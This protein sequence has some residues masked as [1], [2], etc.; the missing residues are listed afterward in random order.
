MNGQFS[1]KL[2]PPNLN[3]M[4]NQVPH[5]AALDISQRI[6]NPSKITI[7]SSI[8]STP[9][10]SRNTPLS[11]NINIGAAPNDTPSAEDLKFKSKFLAAK[12]EVEQMEK[13]LGKLQELIDTANIS[14]TRLKFEKRLLLGAITAKDDYKHA[15]EDTTSE[16]SIKESDENNTASDLDTEDFGEDLEFEQPKQRQT[17]KKRIKLLDPKAPKRPANAFIMFCELSR[18]SIKE[19]RKRTTRKA[20]GSETDIQLLNLTKA[21][22]ARWR[23]L[24]EE[25][26]KVY[27]D[28]FKEQV[29]QY[30]QDFKEY[31]MLYPN[32][33]LEDAQVNSLPKNWTDPDAPTR[34]ANAFFVFC[35]MEDE[36]LKKNRKLDRSEK[37]EEEE[38]LLLSK[39]YGERWRKLS[40]FDRKGILLL[41]VYVEKYEEGVRKYREYMGNKKQSVDVSMG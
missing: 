2:P 27:Q 18:N 11:V 3:S 16:D 17:R 1:T 38:L 24:E 4:Q 22:G 33:P 34:S 32:A 21:L 13:E 5:Q 35:E 41:I 12:S 20:P 29:K 37:E 28:M 26:R 25:D 6:N 19:E 23:Q 15:L 36:R 10:S 7:P 14:V 8:T 31:M 9:M 39:S 30:D 40:D